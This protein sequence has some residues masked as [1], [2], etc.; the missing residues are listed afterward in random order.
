MPNTVHGQCNANTHVKSENTIPEN[1][2]YEAGYSAQGG[3]VDG[4]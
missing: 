4:G 2:N 3:A 1:N